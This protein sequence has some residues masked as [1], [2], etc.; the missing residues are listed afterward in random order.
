[1][2]WWWKLLLQVILKN[3]GVTFD[4][5]FFFFFD[6]HCEISMLFYQPGKICC[7]FLWVWGIISEYVSLH[8]PAF[9]MDVERNLI[10]RTGVRDG[11]E[12]ITWRR[13]WQT[14]VIEIRWTDRSLS[15]NLS[16]AIQCICTA[17]NT[18]WIENQLTH[19]C[20]DSPLVSIL[21]FWLIYYNLTETFF[22]TSL[23]PLEL[24]R[25]AR[26]QTSELP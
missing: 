1:M 7:Q 26:G 24:L 10:E 9:A 18:K 8:F 22:E 23:D 5:I 25:L 20:F 6:R 3:N 15:G 13:F 11:S 4:L 19:E 21:N 16:K 2:C 14:K 17:Y 12:I